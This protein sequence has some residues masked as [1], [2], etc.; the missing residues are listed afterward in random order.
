MGLEIYNW[1]PASGDGLCRIAGWHSASHGG[2]GGVFVH[3]WVHVCGLCLSSDL[4]PSH[5]KVTNIQSDGV[6][7]LLKRQI[8]LLTLV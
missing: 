8:M 3:V 7:V 4:C 1:E 2:V 6:T 5:Y